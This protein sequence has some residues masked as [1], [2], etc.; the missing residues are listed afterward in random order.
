MRSIAGRVPLR[1][2]LPSMSALGTLAVSGRGCFPGLGIPSGI[3]YS[4]FIVRLRLNYALVYIKEKN[5]LLNE[6][7]S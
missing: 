2:F 4:V 1:V 5:R 3:G 7:F 6:N